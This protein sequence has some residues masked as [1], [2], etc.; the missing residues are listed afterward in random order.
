MRHMCERTLSYPPQMEVFMK[1]LVI[2][3]LNMTRQLLGQKPEIP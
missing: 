2:L 3:K 1:L